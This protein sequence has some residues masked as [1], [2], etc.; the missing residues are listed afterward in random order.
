MPTHSPLSSPAATRAALERWGLHTRKSL[1]QHF[2]VS[3]N[4]VG[5]IL[6]LADVQAND[7]VLE[8]GPGIGTLTEALLAVGARV[9]AV[10][11][12]AAL[13]PALCDLQQRYPD[14]FSFQIA[15]ALEVLRQ[16]FR[17]VTTETSPCHTALSTCSFKLVANLPYAAAATLVLAAFE[18]LDGLASA[19]VMV[20][21]EVAQRMR[22]V[23]N[24]KDYGAYTVKLQTLAQPK[25]HFLVAPSNFLP[26]PRVD[27]CVIRIERLPTVISA[28]SDV[29]VSVAAAPPSAA[30]EF[31]RAIFTVADAA[32]YQRR[33][34]IR[35]SMRAYFSTNA[36]RLCFA[37]ADAADAVDAVLAQAKVNPASRGEQHAVEVYQRL[38]LAL[39]QLYPAAGS[40][41]LE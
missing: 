4:V 31:V 14:R 22:A 37:A 15:D 34:T 29:H 33:K 30:P 3:D 17:G 1:G 36:K 9:S 10:E 26:P 8:I 2:L 6:A 16:R 23:P 25:A 11:K 41:S 13:A 28:Q 18:T 20:Q 21:R 32:F 38:G 7:A 40:I 39:L 35:N 19:T 5:R 24:T 27:S 12:D